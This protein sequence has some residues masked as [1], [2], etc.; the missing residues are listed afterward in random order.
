MSVTHDT[1]HVA[2]AQSRLLYQY[3]TPNM[4]ALVAAFVAGA[5]GLEDAIYALDAGRQLATARGK[6]LDLLGE[7]F[8]ARRLGMTDSDFRIA[9]QGTIAKNNSDGTARTVAGIIKLLTGADAVHLITPSSVAA[10]ADSGYVSFAVYGAVTAPVVTAAITRT[11]AASVA[12]GI[13]IAYIAQASV[14][15]FSFAGRQSWVGGFGVGTF[16]GLAH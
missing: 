10:P 4:L 6:Q 13:G 16:A 3:R 9:L 15:A 1:A 12:A 2:E 14:P 7:M 8:G 11:V 5:Q